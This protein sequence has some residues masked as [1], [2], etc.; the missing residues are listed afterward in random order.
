MRL[1][2]F[3]V[4]LLAVVLAGCGLLDELEEGDKKM[5]LYMKKSPGAEEPDGAAPARG[6]KRQ[7]V[8][9]YFASQKNPK[10]FTPGTVSNEIVSCK[11]KSG[12]QFMKQTECVSR[13][14]V[15]GR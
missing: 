12:T 9:E 7:R 10:T 5:D 8:G 1:R 6:G 4:A 3:S 13:G 14:G 11:L 15:P 2:I